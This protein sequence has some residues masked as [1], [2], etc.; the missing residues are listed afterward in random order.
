MIKQYGTGL[1]RSCVS[2]ERNSAL[3]LSIHEDE[4]SAREVIDQFLEGY[5]RERLKT[6]EDIQL[7]IDS[8]R[9]LNEQGIRSSQEKFD[10]EVAALGGEGESGSLA[11]DP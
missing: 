4:R 1:Y 11:L 10:T 5:Q 9:D 7:F 3:C 8:F 2:L 6:M